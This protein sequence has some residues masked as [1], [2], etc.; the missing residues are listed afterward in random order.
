MEVATF[1]LAPVFKRLGSTTLPRRHLSPCKHYDIQTHRLPIPGASKHHLAPGSGLGWLL[2]TRQWLRLPSIYNEV[3]KILQWTI[4]FIDWFL[5]FTLGYIFSQ[6]LWNHIF[7]LIWYYVTICNRLIMLS[8]LD[9]SLLVDLFFF[10]I[11]FRVFITFMDLQ[12]SNCT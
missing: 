10:I 7:C 6:Q 5:Q 1:L 3:T 4:Q 11:S 12:G 2:S 8:L 9:S